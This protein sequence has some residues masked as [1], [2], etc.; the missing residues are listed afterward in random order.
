VLHDAA[1]A[2]GGIVTDV[3]QGQDANVWVEIKVRY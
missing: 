1:R 2:L 3:A